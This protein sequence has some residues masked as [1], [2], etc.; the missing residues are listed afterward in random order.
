M[1]LDLTLAFLALSLLGVGLSVWQVR[2]KRDIGRPSLIDW[3]YVL[4]PALIVTILFLVHATNL[5]L[6]R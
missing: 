2:R 5:L 6:G 1:P 3:H 4:F